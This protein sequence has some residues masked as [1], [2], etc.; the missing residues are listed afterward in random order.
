MTGAGD[1]VP[2][3]GPRLLERVRQACRARQFSPRTAAAYSGW[4]RRYVL[5]HGKRHP[6]AMGSDEVAAFLTHLAD[7][8]GVAS[9]TQ[10]Q[11][12]SALLFLYREVLRLP[13]DPPTGVL[14]PRKPVKR[15]VVLTRAEVA[16]VLREM[17]GLA[18]LV[19]CLL[20]GAGL[21][22]LEALQL[23]LKDI[24]FERREI[25]V[26]SAKGGNDR[27][28]ILPASLVTELERQVAR[29]R[30]LHERDVRNG[31][32]WVAIPGAL[33]RKYTNAG[34]S[35]AWQYVFPATRIHIDR[36]SGQRRRHHL[37]ESAVQ[38][39]VTEAVRRSGILKR[40][41]CHTFRHSFATHLLKAGHDIRVVQVLLGHS[42]VKTTMIYTHVTDGDDGPRVR[43]PLDQL[44]NPDM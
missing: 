6:S 25:T 15:P 33:G 34:R 7:G 32:G 29:A 4:I 30:A 1:G 5:F 21:R 8:E 11:A 44:M 28:V 41:S 27:I 39:A 2:D 13:I 17:E 23:R 16:A 14:R 35:A 40:A 24:D 42:S 9:S 36:A 3:G 10:N 31:A 20:Y 19:A 43:S 18:R 12:A 26:R 38:R 22:L 37:H